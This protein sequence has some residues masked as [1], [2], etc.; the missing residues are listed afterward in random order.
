M[1]GLVD[2]AARGWRLIDEA[3]GG[4]GAAATEAEHMRRLHGHAPGENQCTSA[5]VKHIKAPVH[6]V[7]RP[8]FPLPSLVR[9]SF[10]CCLRGFVRRFSWPRLVGLFLDLGF[11]SVALAAWLGDLVGLLPWW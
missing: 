9:R 4:G 1:V 10:R 3:A 7:R 5:L 6:L 11:S 2:G 8:P